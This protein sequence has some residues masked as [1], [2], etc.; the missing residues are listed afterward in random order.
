MNTFS[1]RKEKAEVL[2]AQSSDSLQSRGLQPARLLCSRNYHPTKGISQQCY[3][4]QNLETQL[5]FEQHGCNLQSAYVLMVAR[6]EPTTDYWKIAMYNW[7]H[8][9][10]THAVQGS[11]VIQ[12]SINS[13]R[14]ILQYII[15]KNTWKKKLWLHETTKW[16]SWTW[17]WMKVTTYKKIFHIYQV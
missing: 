9:V 16:T 7:T 17:C 11:T 5:T 14:D 4:S 13:K 12:M 3:N 10:Q 6:T 2:A 8:A 15:H 1:L